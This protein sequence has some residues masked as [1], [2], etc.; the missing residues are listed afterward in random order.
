MKKVF[1]VTYEGHHI[2][3]ENTWFNGEKLVVDGKLQDQNLG[4]AFDRATLNGVIKNNQGEN[5][6][7][8]VSL[9]GAITVECRIFVDHELIYPD[10]EI[11]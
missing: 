2:Q 9:G 7:I 11:Q 6:Y 5:Q 10:H 4:F 1:E 8:K 3:V